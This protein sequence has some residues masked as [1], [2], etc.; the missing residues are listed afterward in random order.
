MSITHGD[1]SALAEDYSANREGYS[2]TALD[3]LIGLCQIPRDEIAAVD[4]GAGTGIWTRQLA[5]AGLKSVTAIEPN[6]HMRAAG[7]RDCAGFDVTFRAGSGEATG[8]ASDSADLLT[9]ASSFHWVDFD[10]G[11]REFTRVLRPGGWFGALWNPRMIEKSELLI[12][13][14]GY[15]SDINPSLTRIT[16]SRSGKIAELY[17]RLSARPEF[18]TVVYIEG[19]HTAVQSKQRYLG[20]WKSANDV[21]VQLGPDGFSEFMRRVE[22]R[23]A[24]VEQ[25]ETEYLT[26]LWAAR[27]NT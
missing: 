24:G 7:E 1:F 23:I 27:V 17:E 6:Q 19:R 16:S 15:I 10:D 22:A 13:I 14:E 8:L 18:E 12:E 5:Q 26:T 11:V 21:R 9:M 3:A 25:I 2:T 4:V 20:L